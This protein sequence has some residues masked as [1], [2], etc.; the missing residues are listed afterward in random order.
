MNAIHPDYPTL[1]KFS[2]PTYA[3]WLGDV[4]ALFPVP[5]EFLIASKIF[6]F[7]AAFED[8]MTPEEAYAAFDKFVC[9]EEA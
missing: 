1:G 8:D 6:S 3:T 2:P 5:E 4:R 9:C 7:E